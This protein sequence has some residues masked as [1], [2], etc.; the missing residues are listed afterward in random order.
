MKDGVFFVEKVT[1]LNKCVLTCSFYPIDFF[2]CFLSLRR[3]VLY[4][5]KNWD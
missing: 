3:A 1:Q 4:I 5:I 2:F